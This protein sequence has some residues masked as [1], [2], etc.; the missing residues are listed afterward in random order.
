MLP[1]GKPYS[2]QLFNELYPI[3]GVVKYP[4]GIELIRET[5]IERD[6]ARAGKRQE[7]RGLSKQSLHR[8]AFLVLNSQVEFTSI[9][10]LTY[11]SPPP[12]DGRII[13]RQL[14]CFLAEFSQR[15]GKFS[16]LWWLEFQTK[17][18]APHYHLLT[19]L[20][21][22]TPEQVITFANVWT[23]WAFHNAE[24]SPNEEEKVYKVHSF[25]PLPGSKRRAAW[26]KVR[27]T[28][29]AKWYILKYASKAKQKEVPKNFRSPGRFWGCSSDVPNRDGIE[30]EI[31]EP[32]LRDYL[33]SKGLSVTNQEILPKRIIITN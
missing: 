28:N 19:T 11:G 29:G 14:K 23:K 32:E 31:T 18:Q 17:R 4:N 15:V 30:S 33:A 1:D 10:T 24:W 16:Y 7:I 13:K 27:K 12:M 5:T 22:P 20:P 8:L 6:N 3:V 9:I 25:Q 2:S 26:E 21:G